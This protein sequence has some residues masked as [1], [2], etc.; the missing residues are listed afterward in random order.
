ML[1]SLTLATERLP[2]PCRPH[3]TA[4]GCELYSLTVSAP[5]PSWDPMPTPPPA[6]RAGQQEAD[7]S[8]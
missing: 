4:L 1:A 3:P 5:W 2:R 6:P 8:P 7:L